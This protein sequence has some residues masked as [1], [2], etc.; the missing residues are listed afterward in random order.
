MGDRMNTRAPLN[1]YAVLV[2]AVMLPGCG[3]VVNR[4]PVRGLMFVGF[5]LLLGGFTLK[6][7]A[8]DV[9]IV[10]KLAGGIFVYGLSVL[11]AY[12]HARARFEVWRH[13]A[14]QPKSP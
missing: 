6:T 2:V 12:Q 5:M 1:P 11:D 9:S 8:P 3:Q 10:G 4:N 14:D 7:A 13:G